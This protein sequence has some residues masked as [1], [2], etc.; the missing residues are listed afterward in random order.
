MS[1]CTELLPEGTIL[2]DDMFDL[3]CIGTSGSA[4]THT[5]GVRQCADGRSLYVSDLGWGYLDEPWH[6]TELPADELAAC[7]ESPRASLAECTGDG[8]A[9]GR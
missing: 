4:E 8:N 5:A 3:Y 9:V 7:D 6:T 2:R 1:A